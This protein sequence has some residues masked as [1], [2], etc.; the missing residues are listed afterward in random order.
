M[1]GYNFTENV[2]VA[3][4]MAREEAL[5]LQHAFVG[6]EHILLGLSG[7]PESGASAVLRSLGV[8]PAA[9][10]QTVHDAVP[11]G[12]ASRS[13]GQELPYSGRAKKVLELAMNEAQAMGHGYLG[14]EH[15]LVGVLLEKK[16][17][18]AQV[19]QHHEVTPDVLRTAVAVHVDAA[20]GPE[21]AGAARQ[22]RERRKLVVCFL[23]LANFSREC[24]R[25]DDVEIADTLD[26][27]YGRMV[28]ALS[29]ASGRVVKFIGDAALV[30]FDEAQADDGVR[31]ILEFK[32]ETDR[33][34]REAG[35]D[36][37]LDARVH[38]GGVVAGY[39]GPPGAMRFDVVGR[40]VNEAA[41]LKGSGVVATPE[42]Q[43]LL[44]AETR[45]RLAAQ[46]PGSNQ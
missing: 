12:T 18:G 28:A 4:A 10:R 35:W 44:S 39:F 20:K 6:T 17:I 30:T 21:Q 27:F 5:Q 9:L 23:D 42:A 24:E 3:L 26:R 16:G 37:A 14:T 36:C 7:Q 29:A 11:P 13:L 43:A 22:T 32:T 8:D 38:Y 46:Q 31:T 40:A 1:R 25:R 19:L 41:R 45:A 15:L 2:R 34:L 33:G